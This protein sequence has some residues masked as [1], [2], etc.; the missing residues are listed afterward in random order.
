MGL[1]IENARHIK[2]MERRLIESIEEQMK[3]QNELVEETQQQTALKEDFASQLQ[4]FCTQ[5]DATYDK[6]AELSIHNGE[7]EQTIDELE[8]KLIDET[9][10]RMELNERLARETELREI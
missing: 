2:D 1:M 3:L 7:L 9:K 4:M 8:Q 6:Q 5:L 10:F